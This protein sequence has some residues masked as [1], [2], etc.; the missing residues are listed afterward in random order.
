MN[1]LLNKKK[2][3]IHNKILNIKQYFINN[4]ISLTLNNK[5]FNFHIFDFLFF[6]YIV[7]NKINGINMLN[8]PL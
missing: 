2:E 8:V 6:C 5:I 4:I 1:Y 3:H 7:F